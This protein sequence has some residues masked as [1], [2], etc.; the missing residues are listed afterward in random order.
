[1]KSQAL[2]CPAVISEM[3]TAECWY[4]LACW[5][6]PWVSSTVREPSCLK[7]K[8]SRDRGGH[9]MPTSGSQTHTP[10]RARR[11]VTKPSLAE[12]QHLVPGESKAWSFTSQKLQ[13]SRPSRDTHGA[14]S[15]DEPR[16]RLPLL[17]RKFQETQ[18]IVSIWPGEA[19][20]SCTPAVPHKPQS[21]HG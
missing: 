1:M 18:G 14:D 11:H 5:L 19:G 16:S 4:S 12:W 3:G 21:L 6:S 9:L 20:V 15:R 13:D 2:R 10:V 8:G 17:E 7:N